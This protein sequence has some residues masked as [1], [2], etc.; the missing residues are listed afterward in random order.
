MTTVERATTAE[1]RGDGELW[2][3]AAPGDRAR[4]DSSIYTFESRD[5]SGFGTLVPR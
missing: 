4:P 1:G 3:A 2:S 5:G